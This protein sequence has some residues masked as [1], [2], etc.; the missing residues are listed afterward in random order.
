[1]Q[2]MPWAT[3]CSASRSGKPVSS[4]GHLPRSHPPPSP[5][6]PADI[7]GPG[8]M[9]RIISLLLLCFV[10]GL[11]MAWLGVTPQSLVRDAWGTLR[12]VYETLFGLVGWAAPYILLGATVVVPV[13]LVG[14]LLRLTRR[15]P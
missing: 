11:A 8:R 5:V 7:A 1:M 4:L 10:V 13:A 6:H 9:G 3:R 2:A 15:R 12:H 14:F